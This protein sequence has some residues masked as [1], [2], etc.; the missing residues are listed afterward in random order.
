[1][2]LVRN[3]SD[4]LTLVTQI[5]ASNTGLAQ[6]IAYQKHSLAGLICCVFV[7]DYFLFLVS[8]F[9]TNG[10]TPAHLACHLRRPT[11]CPALYTIKL[12]IDDDDDDDNKDV[13]C[14]FRTFH[15]MKTKN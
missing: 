7:V 3:S 5:K 10:Q 13:V 2:H 6:R 8:C 9:Y 4:N 11:L 14:F 15:C 12:A 1:M